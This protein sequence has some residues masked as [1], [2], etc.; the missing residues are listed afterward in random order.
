MSLTILLT[1]ITSTSK[2]IELNFLGGDNSFVVVVHAQGDFVE[3]RVDS[4]VRVY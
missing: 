4:C 1:W 3:P 2:G